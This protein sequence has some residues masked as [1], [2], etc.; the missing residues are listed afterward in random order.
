[1]KYPR[2]LFPASSA[3]L[4]LFCAAALTGQTKEQNVGGH[5]HHPRTAE[6]WIKIL[7][8]PERDEWQKPE[9]VVEAL[10]LKAGQ[11]VADIGAGSGYF[12]VRFARETGPEGKVFAADIDEGL[13]KHL[14]HRAAEEGLDSL[15]AIHSAPDDPKL[16]AASVDLVFIC[17]VVHHIGERQDYHAKLR[18]ALRS[19]GRLAIVDFYKKETPVGPPAA[20]RISKQE[21]IAELKQAGFELSEEFGFLPYQYFLIFEP[22]AR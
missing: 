8:D 4:L 5:H 16:P 22:L 17:N 14:K 12:S 9:Q 21:M 20:M 18:E 19:G 6:E 10:G 2:R 11:T 3:L 7:E 1:M 13:V 15:A